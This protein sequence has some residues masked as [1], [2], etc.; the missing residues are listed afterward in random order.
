MRILVCTTQVPFAR[1]GAEL[2]SEGLRDALRDHG[3]EAEIVALP[4]AW[5]PR[6]NLLKSALTWRL[7][8]L[9]QVGGRPVD[10]IICTK[11]PSYAARHPRKIVWLVHQ[12]RQAYD[13]Y[14][15]RLS[16][17]GAQPGDAEARR[18]LQRLDRR[19]LGEAHRLFAISRNV[20]ARL[21]RFNDLQAMPLYPPSHLMS[22]LKPGPFDDYILSISRLDAAK[23]IDLLLHA[24][25]R[26][27]APLRAIIAG[28]GPE[29]ESLRRLAQAL[30]LGERV[31]FA[32][33]V[34]DTPALDLFARCRAVYYAPV[35]EDYGLAT[36]EAFAAGK[37]VLTTADAG[38]VLEF[39]QNGISGFVTA[40][41]ADAL[42]ARIDQLAD[43]TTARRLG[44]DN[45]ARVAEIN[46]EHVVTTLLAS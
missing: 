22:R 10:A 4:F 34:E 24:L 45:L 41:E 23:R 26:S 30:G 11:F 8:D 35:D 43:V 37:P 25:A 31:Q 20:A 17:W 7:L 18:L 36:I 42:A 5:T 15:T 19:T 38:G 40:P 44:A 2:L 9:T 46:W 14:G 13:W 12:H 33:F 6:P 28:R 32:G 1:G 16:D 21:R 29:Q 27:R 39:V 3:H